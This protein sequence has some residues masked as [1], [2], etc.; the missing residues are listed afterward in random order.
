VR[1]LAD[2]SLEYV[3]R[4]D[5]QVKIRGFRI[6]LGE[7]E[8]ALAGHEAVAHGVV[9]PQGSA[10]SRALVAYVSPTEQWLDDAARE[11]NAALLAQWS[12]VFEEQYA[13]SQGDGTP[14]DLNLA[15]WDS[16][17]TGEP[18]PESDMREWIDG[19]VRLI[20]E[21]RP[22]RLLEVG[23][24][25][26][27]L[28]F[29]YADSCASVHAVDLSASAL[30][31][32]R[33]G[34]ERRGWSHV[35]LEQGDALSV[36][37]LPEGTFDTV[38][39]NSVVQY[40]PNQL[41]LEQAI[42]RL[43]PLVAEGGRVLIG[44]VR[45]L[46]LYPAH[47]GA[48]ERGRTGAGTTA[49]ALAAQVR[50]RRRQESE[51]LLS[52]TYFARLTERFPE[53]GAVD[54]MVK[55]G[56]GDNEMLAYR[57]D[58]VL[59]KGAT[60]PATPLTWQEAT[61]PAQLR[62]LLDGGAP[63]RFGVSGLANP[64]I[65][66]DV[67]VAEGLTR[68]SPTREVEPLPD[69]SRLTTGAAGQVRELE[70]ALGHAERLGYRVAATWSQSRP[71]ELDLVLGRGE[72]PRV[73]A[74]APYRA[75]HLANFP[76]LG[77]AGPAMTRTLKEH[78]SAKLPDY[79][80]PGVFVL[81]E[82]LPLTPNGKVEKRALPAP[83]EED[84]AKEVYVA[85]RTEAQRTLCRL[86][87]EVLELGRVGIRDGFLDL[88]GH[89]LLAVRLAMRVAKETGVDL[90]LQLIL[91]GATV[92]EM[93]AVLERDEA[94][95]EAVPLV[96]AVPIPDGEAAPLA[97]QQRDLWF[98]HRPEHLGTSYDNAQIAFRLT[99]PLDRDAYMRSV[100]SLVDRHAM[101]RTGFV[102]RDDG[103][104]TQR[105]HDAA[106][107]AVNVMAV[108]DD[109]AV[110][111]WLRAER[112]R[113]F[114]PD[115]RHMF[116]AHLLTLT[117]HEH[118]VAITRPW[119]IFDGWSV[120]VLLAELLVV[121]SALSR[122][123]APDLPPLPVR[124]ADF[125]RWQGQ[126][127]DAAE[128]GRQQEYWRRQLAGLPARLSLRTDYPRCPVR[129]HQ[130]SS[131]DFRIPLDLL[132]RLRRLSQERGA[133]LY[134]TLLAA[135]A[136]LIGGH[137]DDRELAIATPVTNRPRAE[138]EQLVGYFVNTLVMRL[139]VAADRPFTELLA[140]ARQVTAE[141]HEHKDLPFADLVR[142]LVPEPDP[143]HPPLA[144]VM[145]N[146]IPTPPPT[147][148][149]DEGPTELT[150]TP[151]P[152]DP[153][154]ARFDLALTARET[155]AGLHCSLEYSTDLFARGTAARMA[156]SYERLL[157]E[158]VAA[159]EADLARLRTGAGR[160]AANASS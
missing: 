140:Q 94:A 85:P 57:Y 45:N 127:V 13:G 99:G 64:R 44:D 79:M 32:V 126:A 63:D 67:R 4:N 53:L 131:L 66:E 143:A 84:M 2:G 7:I 21:L 14:D 35:T 111:E 47:A 92:E 148:G 59:T 110:A 159:P 41:Y 12:H 93:A 88:G 46:D 136:A 71:D 137:T 134:M 62:A 108:A 5:D 1:Q 33:R 120:R 17:Y 86:V 135:F 81:L 39:I 73:Q 69:A 133:T 58:V 75:S 28:L 154:P 68:W 151:M 26:G 16:S 116:R 138:L 76:R 114:A 145:F 20:E 128:L 78:L 65:A 51:L 149:A 153:G 102:R 144:Q 55:R 139:G 157:R 119:G 52:P 160:P 118:V 105:V 91:T 24:G 155:E 87:A 147:A 96:P 56:V 146:L 80:V 130:G 38:V 19:T 18:I 98:L 82:E 25:T 23:C 11:Q 89:S 150:V 30:D 61:T 117:D 36:A 125:A 112:A 3:G 27:L 72:L 107:F 50:R 31:D 132:G 15:G 104:V 83:D 124:Y 42:A 60:A 142:S 100:Q 152:S 10:D 90:P 48:I 113:P 109:A 6:E 34:A 141:G 95:T 54:L 70:A 8:A 129:S 22:K 121:Y 40:F 9:V 158:I 37:A 77:D 101:L 115:G 97:L 29:R 103:A 123:R 156:R 106:G 74:R 122:G 49:G 43:L